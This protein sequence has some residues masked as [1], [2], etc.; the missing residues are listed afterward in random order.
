MSNI[1]TATTLLKHFWYVKSDFYFKVVANISYPQIL[2]GDAELRSKWCI[3][4]AAN[5]D[6]A[7]SNLSTIIRSPHVA[8]I[9]GSS[10]HS[11]ASCTSISKDRSS[12]FIGNLFP[13]VTEN[14]LRE[15]FSCYGQI[16]S[17]RII[18]KSLFSKMNLKQ[19]RVFAFVKYENFDCAEKAIA[20]Q[21]V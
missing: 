18:R 9:G 5:L 16:V 8:R 17:V 3:D 4:W 1:S 2:R 13:S 20:E 11:N 6:V 21:V 7:A 10:R 14:I 15:R 12:V 19:E